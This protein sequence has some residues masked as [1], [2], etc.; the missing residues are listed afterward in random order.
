VGATDRAVYTQIPFEPD[1]MIW[2]KYY[3]PAAASNP[4][5]LNFISELGKT[6]LQN[7]DFCFLNSLNV[8]GDDCDEAKISDVN[9][10]LFAQLTG[11]DT[12]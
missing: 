3:E 7:H 6:Y 9:D 10:K 5:T 8:L 11:K 12:L 1:Q 2:S 4:L